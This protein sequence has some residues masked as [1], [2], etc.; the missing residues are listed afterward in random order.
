VTDNQNSVK[1]F[2]LSVYT[3]IS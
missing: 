1:D 2:E 3:Y